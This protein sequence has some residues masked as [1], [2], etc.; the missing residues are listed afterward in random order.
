MEEVEGMAGTRSSS[1]AI[2]HLIL[3]ICAR[4]IA[5]TYCMHATSAAAVRFTTQSRLCP[6]AAPRRDR[7]VR[8]AV[9]SSPT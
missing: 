1:D 8:P 6:G 3:N 2:V 9:G 7:L 4:C 5:N